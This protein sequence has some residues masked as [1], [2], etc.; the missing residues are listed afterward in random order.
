MGRP[1]LSAAVFARLVPFFLVLPLAG[2]PVRLVAGL[3]FSAA[4][5]PHGPAGPRPA[6]PGLLAEALLGATLGV[7]AGIPFHAA[8]GLRADGPLTLGFAGRIWAWAVFFA[9]GGPGML[10]ASLA[11]TFT[12][13]PAAAWPQATT[14]AAQ[15][16]LLFYGALVFGLPL[17]LA[18]LLVEPV[19][20]FVDRVAAAPLLSGGAIAARGV[21]VPL[22]IV[23]AAPFLMDELRGL[24]ATLLPESPQ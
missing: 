19:A 7:L 2:W 6:L 8:R 5:S 11:R 23:L 18:A 13:L 12:I 3:V 15:G 10:L 22:A 17:F 21:L 4:L 14:I 24:F 9:V 1:E 16:H 20:A